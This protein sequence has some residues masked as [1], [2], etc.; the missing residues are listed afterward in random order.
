MA[1]SRRI[2]AFAACAAVL[3]VTA[4]TTATTTTATTATTTAATTPATATAAGPE[5]LDWHGC[6]LGADDETG[7]RLDA[8]GADC[9]DITVPLDYADPGGRTITVAISRLKATDTAHR[10]GALLLN[11]GVRPG[12][13]SICR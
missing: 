1:T 10:V 8:A 5:S 12:P 7:R 2:K 3:A 11:D 6:A 13:A 4:T 9:A